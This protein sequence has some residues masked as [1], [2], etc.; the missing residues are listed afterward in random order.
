MH[1]DCSQ[2]RSEEVNFRL[3]G[4]PCE[5]KTEVD[6]TF[7]FP[8]LHVV[9]NKRCQRQTGVLLCCILCRVLLRDAVRCSVRSAEQYER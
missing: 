3:K 4:G 6:V 1:F 2:T 7:H 9:L 8:V 5:R